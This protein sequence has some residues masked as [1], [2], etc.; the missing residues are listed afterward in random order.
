MAIT[1]TGKATAAPATAKIAL[2]VAPVAKKRPLD[3][4][5][6]ADHWTV[7]KGLL[8]MVWPEGRPDLR[9][10]VVAAFAVLVI[11]KLVTVAAPIAFKN[12]TDWLTTNAPAQNAAAATAQGLT[13]AAAGP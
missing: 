2:T 8:P 13:L 1:D 7:F 9:M 10:R 12:A 4:T 3:L 11:A 5:G 6:D